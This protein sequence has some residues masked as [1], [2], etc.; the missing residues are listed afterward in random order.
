MLTRPLPHLVTHLVQRQG[1]WF[2]LRKHCFAS[3]AGVV[4]INMLKN[5]GRTYV[6]CLKRPT[7]GKVPEEWSRLS[8]YLTIIIAVS[9]KLAEFC[10]CR[11]RPGV[12]YIRTML[13]TYLLLFLDQRIS[14]ERTISPVNRLSFE[15]H[16]FDLFDMKFP[17]LLFFRH[18]IK[19]LVRYYD[20]HRRRLFRL[21]S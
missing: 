16:T 18:Y 8:Y 1:N 2:C 9:A 7:L 20:M 15:R 5:L 3:S 4:F 12:D 11:W 6:E 14:V 19:A 17:S 21:V 10:C 13:T